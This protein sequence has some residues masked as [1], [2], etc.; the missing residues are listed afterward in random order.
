[1]LKFIGV[2]G[3]SDAVPLNQLETAELLDVEERTCGG[4]CRRYVDE[5]SWWESA[6]GET[7]TSSSPC[8]PSARTGGSIDAISGCKYIPDYLPV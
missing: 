5:A 1:M 3:H 2:L 6:L 4:W 7:A 8:A